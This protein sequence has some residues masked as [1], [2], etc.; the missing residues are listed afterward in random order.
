MR[1]SLRKNIALDFIGS[2]GLVHNFYLVHVKS[3]KTTTQRADKIS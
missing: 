2:D 3:L 1:V